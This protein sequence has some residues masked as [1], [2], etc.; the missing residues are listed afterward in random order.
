LPDLCAGQCEPLASE[1][2]IP[3]DTNWLLSDTYPDPVTNERVLFLYDMRVG[4]QRDLG[5]F[6]ADPKLGKENRC[7][8]HPR[9][10]RD[11]KQICIDSVHESGRQMYIVDVSALVKF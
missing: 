6:Y 7:D 1:R 8:L 2:K 11:G 9:W 10:R 3:V 4:T 5:H